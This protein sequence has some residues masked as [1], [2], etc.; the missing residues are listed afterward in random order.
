MANVLSNWPEEEVKIA[1]LTDGERILGLGDLGCNGMGIPVGRGLAAAVLTITCGVPEAS[2]V[3]LLTVSL[4]KAAV[5]TAGAGIHP[6]YTLPITLDV[7]CNTASVREAPFYVGLR[8]VAITQAAQF[9]PLTCKPG[10]RIAHKNSCVLPL[11]MAGSVTPLSPEK[12]ERVRGQEYDDFI[13]EIL[14]CLRQR[15]GTS[16]VI[17]WEDFGASNACQVPREGA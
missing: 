6:R 10:Q 7:G 3:L 15:Y 5:H 14:T 8:Q 9:G 16:L 11:L 13:D 1:I 17:H 2:N 12:Q 4:G